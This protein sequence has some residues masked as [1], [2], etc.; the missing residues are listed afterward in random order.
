[1][2]RYLPE[3]EAGEAAIRTAVKGIG[4]NRRKS[5]KKGVSDDPHVIAERLAFAQEGITWSRQR[6]QR[7]MFSDEVRAMGGAHTDSWV[8]V[9]DGSD[10]FLPENLTH[11]YSK[12]PA[13][14]FHGTIIDGRKGL[15]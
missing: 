7:Q 10:R 12:A 14:M 6:L 9:E 13:W 8:T 11:K 5:H 1:M 4:Y 3:L 15:A 2:P